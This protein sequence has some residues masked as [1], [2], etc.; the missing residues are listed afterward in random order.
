MTEP[1]DQSATPRV[2]GSSHAEPHK[3]VVILSE[4]AAANE[5]KDLRLFLKRIKPQIPILALLALTACRPHDFPTYPP[6][7][8]EYAYVANTGSNTVTVL[9][10]VNIRV[11]RELAVGVTPVALAASPTR[12]EIYVVNSGPPGASGSLSVIDATRNAVVAAI[13][14]HRQPVSIHLDSAG[15]LA[16]VANS[17]SNSISV[18]DLAARR[19]VAL[20]GTGEQPDAAV[21]APDGKTLVVANRAA[22]SVALLDPASGIVRSVFQNC[23]GAS[24]PVILA[25]S[26]KVFVPCSAGH[27]VIV[28]ALA[29]PADH[30]PDQLQTFIDVGRAP[31][32]LALKPDDGELF[33]SNSFSDS[34]SEV[35]TNSNDVGGAYMI[36]DSPV[37]GLVSSDNALL[38]VA[39]Q[40]SQ[41][42]SVYSIDDG[43]LIKSIR[44]GDGPSDLAF[45]ADGNFLFAVDS[46]SG[47]V[48]VI[49]TASQS[50]YAFTLL[51]AGRNPTSIVDKS[52]TL[53]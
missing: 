10:A 34:I 3:V 24:A 30:Q 7:Y 6:N 52:F 25:D 41:F 12:K 9:D 43:K 44:V 45:S 36:G 18:I 39:N 33:A 46:R 14:L 15:K 27:Q 11:D 38:Y 32:H 40:H 8:R 4:S 19:E 26:S 21:V 50:L 48:A 47:D 13:P 29:R 35:V 16:Y 23:P 51:P 22:N 20:F 1:L 53:P 2:N 49:R 17:G 5:S 31:V 42:V 28:I 37:R